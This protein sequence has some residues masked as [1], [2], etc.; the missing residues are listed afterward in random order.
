M[1]AGQPPRF[2]SCVYWSDLL[3]ALKCAA[4]SPPLPTLIKTF[5]RLNNALGEFWRA[6]TFTHT[7]AQHIRDPSLSFAMASRRA[8][9]ALLLLATL[10]APAFARDTHFDNDML[11]GECVVEAAAGV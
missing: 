7:H 1:R 6:P 9:V 2:H 11:P 10:A 5:K 3:C 4:V 8:L